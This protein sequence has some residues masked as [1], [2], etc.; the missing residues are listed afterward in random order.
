MPNGVNALR[1]ATPRPQQGSKEPYFDPSAP[2]NVS[3]LI[4]KSAYLTCKV[5]NIGNRTVSWVRH[6]DIHILTV[7]TYTYTSDQRFM[8]LH[9][10]LDDDWTLQIKWVQKRD[11]GVYECQISTLPVQGYFI[12]L[13]IV[14]PETSTS[15]T[16]FPVDRFIYQRMY[17]DHMYKVPTASI[18]GGPDIY[19]NY[20]STIN[21]TCTIRHSP[22]PPAYI[23]W[24]YSK[25][26]DNTSTNAPSTKGPVRVVSYDSERGGVSIIT[27][28]G[29][30]TTS[31]LLITNALPTDEGR[32]SCSPSNADMATVRVH[33][34]SGESPA[35][36]QTG[37]SQ[38][39]KC[40]HALTLFIAITST[41]TNIIRVI[42]L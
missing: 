37:A 26:D 28:K 15:T 13:N 6:R 2:Q 8:A 1:G 24:Y 29:D 39:L 33:V 18:V 38:W 19:V 16:D 5:R 11:A 36:M 22:E 17:M 21:L 40:H 27:D 10:P 4:G 34:L 30:V 25:E 3:A 42:R 12:N 35:A 41:W 9:H 23:F 32:Y 7:S 20:G 31:R 14:E